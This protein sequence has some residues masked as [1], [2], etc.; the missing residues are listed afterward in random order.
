MAVYHPIPNRK[1]KE[2]E[3]YKLFPYCPIKIIFRKAIF[4]NFLSCGFVLQ[5]PEIIPLFHTFERT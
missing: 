4:V 3:R 2:T 1:I 5:A